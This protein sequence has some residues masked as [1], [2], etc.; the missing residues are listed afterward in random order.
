MTQAA[1]RSSTG[2]EQHTGVARRGV[3][4]VVPVACCLE[5][6][7][8]ALLLPWGIQHHQCVRPVLLAHHILKH[9]PENSP[10]S[11]GAPS[12]SSTSRH[13][14][15]HTCMHSQLMLT[16]A[17]PLSTIGTGKHAHTHAHTAS[18][19]PR[20]PPS[21]IE[22]EH[23][24]DSVGRSAGS[25]CPTAGTAPVVLPDTPEGRACKWCKSMRPSTSLPY[26][27]RRQGA[28]KRSFPISAAV[29]LRVYIVP[30]MPSP[31]ACET[32]RS[33]DSTFFSS[34]TASSSPC[35]GHLWAS[36]CRLHIS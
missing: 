16:A 32:S 23:A 11:A 24:F 8:Q 22:V 15:A 19:C 28:P 33:P 27:E 1:H 20:I 17:Q 6:L 2:Q 12:G 3:T 36:H 21:T 29:L 25:H 26:M 14:P 7:P 10:T 18:S 35:S 13:G 9:P 4:H 31:A 34:W 5:L 30:R